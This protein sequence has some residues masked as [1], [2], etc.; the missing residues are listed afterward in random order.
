MYMLSFFRMRNV[1]QTAPSSVSRALKARM[2]ETLNASHDLRPSM[3]SAP[4]LM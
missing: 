4:D 2:L 1:F 3:L